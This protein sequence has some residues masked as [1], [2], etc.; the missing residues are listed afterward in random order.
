MMNVLITGGEGFI[1]GH[2][3]RKLKALEHR[4]TVV[5]DMSGTQSKDTKHTPHTSL[6]GSAFGTPY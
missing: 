5:D 2:L 3:V 6:S 4:V 1:G